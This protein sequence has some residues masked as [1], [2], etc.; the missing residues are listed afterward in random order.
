VN[1][2]KAMDYLIIGGVGYLI[3]MMFKKAEPPQQDSSGGYV[4]ALGSS[5][6]STIESSRND[7]DTHTYELQERTTTSKRILSDGY[8][9]R[10]YYRILEDGSE[11][12]RHSTD[13]ASTYRTYTGYLGAGFLTQQDLDSA[14]PVGQL[15]NQVNGGMS[16]AVDSTTN[17][18]IGARNHSR[19]LSWR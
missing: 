5:A 13:Y 10:K 17:S 8:S 14:S 7:I 19:T 2:M 1:K 12:G 9:V 6:W 4:P 15:V 16:S 18:A 11:R 3:L